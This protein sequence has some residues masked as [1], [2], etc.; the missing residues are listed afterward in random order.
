MLEKAI[1]KVLE[2][3]NCSEKDIKRILEDNEFY[4]IVLSNGEGNDYD[5]PI[6]AVDKKSNK[7][8]LVSYDV[9]GLKFLNRLEKAKI[10]QNNDFDGEVDYD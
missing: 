9:D 7:L 3:Y 2:A 5:L 10:I 4:F 6:F 1:N 8:N